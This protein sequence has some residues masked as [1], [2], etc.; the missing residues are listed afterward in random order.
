[1]CIRDR[2]AFDRERVA[3]EFAVQA[4]FAVTNGVP[5]LGATLSRADVWQAW[6]ERMPEPRLWGELAEADT[7]EEVFA[8]ALRGVAICAPTGGG[9]LAVV[10][11]D[12][13]SLNASTR[14]LELFSVKAQWTADDMAPYLEGVFDAGCKNAAE[15]LLRYTRAVR[16]QPGMPVL[17]CRR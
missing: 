6:R 16:D 12:N 14:F 4:V 15:L 11:A 7:G 17:H 13:L 5:E 3:R 1:M 9:R 2:L 8:Q 10:L